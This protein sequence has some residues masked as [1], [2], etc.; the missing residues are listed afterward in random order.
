[1]KQFIKLKDQ[2]EREL[3]GAL[4]FFR[5]GDFYEL[6][7]Q[8][9]IEAAP[10]L[11]ITLT[12]RNS[13]SEN[14]VPMAG[15]PFHSATNYIQKLLNAGKKV[16][17]AEQIL[18]E[19]MTVDQI[20]GIVDRQIIRTFTPA[21][22][23]EIQGNASQNFLATVAPVIAKSG[24]S[25]SFVLAMLEPAT[26]IVRVS[27]ALNLNDLM[28]ET[29]LTAIKHF[30]NHSSKTPVDFLSVL[31]SIPKTLVEE[32]PHNWVS[33]SEVAPFL[34]KQYGRAVLHPLL[35]EN[36]P[37][38]KAVA[39]LIQYV[40]KTQGLEILPHLHEP[41]ALHESDRLVVGPHTHTHLDSADL[42]TLINQTATSMGSRHLYNLLDAPFKDVASIETQQDAV[43]ELAAVSLEATQ[44]HTN[45]REVYDLDRILGRISTKLAHPR[46]TYALGMSMKNAFQFDEKLSR[47][48]SAKLRVLSDR[49]SKARVELAS[50]A[51]QIV[52]T[53]KADA[54]LHTREGG[55]FEM[56]TDPELDRLITLTT[57]GEKFVVD[58]EMREREATGIGSLKVKYNR[59]FG[60]FIEI[61]NAN[62][63]NVPSHYQRK[64]STVGGERFFTEELKRFEE[65]I[66]SAS[67]KQKALE[68]SLFQRL[69]DDLIVKAEALKQLSDVI[70]ELDSLIA[71]SFLAQ[72]G[73]WAFP[74][75]DDSFE[76]KLI[77]SRHPVVDEVLRGKFV[78]NDIELSPT[79][80]RT[81]I[82]TGP[83][84]GG[85][86][87]LMRQMAQIILLG[88][89]GAP[90]PASEAHWGIFHSLY[91][92]IGAQDAI[93]KGQS[94][95]MVEM[96][97]LAHILT[98]ANERSFVVLDEIGR[99]TS[100]Y[101]GMSVASASLEYL[102]T[103]SGA[104][105]VFATHYH[106]LTDLEAR[107]PGLKNTHMKVLDEK[108]KLTFLYE[109]ALGRSSKSFGIQVAEL[110]GLPK[111]V[112]KQAW[113]ILKELETQAVSTHASNGQLSLF[114]APAE[115]SIV[116]ED[117]SSFQ[118]L[119]TD[120]PGLTIASELNPHLAELTNE[121]GALDLNSM[122]PIDALNFLA[123][124]QEKLKTV[125]LN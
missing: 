72:K 100:T 115:D 91:T 71:I 97:E 14:P 26:G 120:S 103:R 23:F 49:F 92:R 8:D 68:A 105:I 57:E 82:I 95:F 61:S 75:I 112:I 7:G 25:K 89:I 60:Y 38:Q 65:E 69:V 88:Q 22:Q 13:K 117:Q 96:V 81:L 102:H 73:A 121:L 28:A 107:L 11:G 3:G 63:K 94:T 46:D 124:A 70:G 36:A 125:S 16:A 29:S 6:F 84:M 37:A 59:V 77:G 87:T 86:S 42:F 41:Q 44:I 76:F 106:E 2:A 74:K 80:A 93:T 18:P 116:N 50:I 35:E 45:L 51:E 118:D 113:N 4:L 39:L 64:Q 9:A 90:V 114:S 34:K 52:R 108:G 54:P 119:G 78:P 58:L 83:N 67:S 19:G 111:P 30:L 5:M 31:E 66:L 109:I 56:G 15:I 123:Q 55:I 122:R 20:K 53:Q 99:G 85:K 32:I 110:A 48:E 1:M 104:R 79:Q 27:E 98:H 43:K 33:D 24:E 47:F 17:I 21:V 40:L 101:D 62:L 10:I 12:A